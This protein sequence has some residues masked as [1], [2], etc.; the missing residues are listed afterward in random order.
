MTSLIFHNPNCGTSRNTLAILKASGEQPNVVEYLK[1]PPTREYLIE[2]LTLMSIAPRDL[3]RRKGTPYDELNLDNPALSDDQLIDAM[4]AHPILINRPIVVTDKGAA[5]CRPSERVFELLNNPVA[6]FK[7]EDGEVIQSD[8]DKALHASI[9]LIDLPNIDP[10]NIRSID[11]D[12]LIGPNDLRHPPKILVLYGS[13]RE[14][15]FSKLAAQEASRLLRWY[16]CEVRTFD[17][18]GLPL[19]DS[20]DADHPKV[21]E[22]RELAAWSEG[23]LWVSPERHGS[24]TSIMKAQID[25]IPLSL[26]G[27]RPT[28]GKTLAVMQVSGG[29]QSFNTVNQLRILGR[30]MRMITIPNQSS[31]PKAFLEFD[32][33]DRMKMS[34]L[35]TRIVDVCEELVKFTW[36]TRGRSAYLTDRYSERVENAEEVSQRVNQKPI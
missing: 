24:I 2:L 4:V 7:K 10:E 36:M 30:W 19:P 5:L 15:S 9:D 1:T 29:S 3:L 23:M 14:R 6:T 17:P 18:A 26:G 27:V 12:S 20:T 25:W 8:K 21:Q 22:L 28:Q 31:I 35:Y 16:G 11:I 13:L 32:D 34:P 33:D